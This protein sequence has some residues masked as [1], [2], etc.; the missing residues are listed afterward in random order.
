MKNVL[1]S[2]LL[3]LAQAARTFPVRPSPSTLWR[4]RSRGIGGVRLETVMVGGRRY[5]SREAL[6]RFVGELT[7]AREPQIIP[8]AARSPQISRDLVAAKLLDGPSPSSDAR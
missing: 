1:L 4:W 6:E 2:D 3:T 7:A 8:V 5:V